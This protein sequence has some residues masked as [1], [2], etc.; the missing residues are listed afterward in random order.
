[1]PKRS[2]IAGLPDSIKADLNKRLVRG[3]FSNYEKLAAWLQE[4]GFEISRSAVHR[5]GQA[6]EER[7]AAI[8]I[9]TE[10][11]QAIAEAVGDDEGAM[12]EAL[13][14]L[15][16]EKS[17]DVL[18]NLQTEDPDAFTKI[19]PKLGVM[20]AKL[21]KASVDQKKWMLEARKKALEEAANT[22]ETAARREGVSKATINK[23]RREVLQM[24]G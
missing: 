23:I 3:G 14:R 11:A 13:I 21:S 18:V 15:V 12:N 7:L 9:A 10:Q 1:M 24:N 19:F 17:F 5:Y 6:F 8:K 4:Q 20:I 2:K 22:I 16:Q